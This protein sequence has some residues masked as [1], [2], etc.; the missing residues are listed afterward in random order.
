MD[1]NVVQYDDW[2]DLYI[3]D[4][5]ASSGHSLHYSHLLDALGLPYNSF[6]IAGEEGEDLA[7][8][9]TFNQWKET[10]DNQSH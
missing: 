2:V 10:Y 1:I 5:L 3:D 9:P 6:Y 4:K 7:G 8:L